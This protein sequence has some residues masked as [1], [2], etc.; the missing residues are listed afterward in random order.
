[1][2]P[3]S[4]VSDLVYQFTNTFSPG[5][6]EWYTFPSSWIWST[7]TLLI[8][9]SCLIRILVR[10]SRPVVHGATLKW[11][12]LGLPV[13]EYIFAC[14]RRVVYFSLSWIWSTRTQFILYSC[15]IHVLI[16]KSRPLVQT[17]STF[18]RIH[19][20]RY[21]KRGLLF[22]RVEAGLPVHSSYSTHVWYAFSWGGVDQ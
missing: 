14:I 8:L 12:R 5:Y 2:V 11:F 4:S 19:F 6:E 18:S 15:L 16:N 3:R 17:W 13:Y 1:M 10:R 22:H 20:R 7:R 9:Y 21:T